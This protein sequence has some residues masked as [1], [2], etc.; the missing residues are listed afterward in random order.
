M[1]SNVKFPAEVAKA[2]EHYVYRLI[3]PRNAD[4]FYVG[5]GKGDRVFQHVLG[6]LPEN[7]FEET[8]DTKLRRIR[9]IQNAG[10]DV[11]HVI[12]RHGLDSQTAFE[13]EAALMDAYPGIAN[14]A[15]GHGNADRGV[16]HSREIIERYSA[17]DVEIDDNCIEILVQRSAVENNIYDGTRFAWR[18]D[19]RRARN[20][21]FALAVINGIVVEVFAIDDWFPATAENF[22]L[23]APSEGWP[24][25]FGF[26]GSKAPTG[27]R[28][29]Y[30]RKRMPRRERGA[31]NPIRYFNV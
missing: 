11:Q 13:V 24:G 26:V 14:I 30:I 8:S 12:H 15:G 21:S 5:K 27:I 22:P 1:E 17:D 18:L 10:F 31:A 25:R 3:D 6:Q 7:G 23:L 19:V 29:K 16:A 2:L 4:T 20:A 9:E 28:A